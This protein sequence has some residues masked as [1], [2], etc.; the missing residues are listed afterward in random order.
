MIVMISGP[1]ASGKTT[2]ADMLERE[3]GAKRFRYSMLLADLARERGLDPDDKATLQQLFLSER[4]QRGEDFLANEMG[5]RVSAADAALTVVEG[6][7]RIADIE[8]LRAVARA[9]E[10]ELKLVFIEA[11]AESRFARYNSRLRKNG[12]E[13]VSREAFEVLER[14]AAENEIDNL[15]EIFGREGLLVDTSMLAIGEG[16]ARVKDFLRL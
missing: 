1:T 2:I 4:E 9:Q 6:A 8:A 16:E 5:L 14:N 7:R 12:E 15:R 3:H 10:E 13:P 11:S